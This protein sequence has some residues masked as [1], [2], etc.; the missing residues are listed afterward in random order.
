MTKKRGRFSFL[1]FFFRNDRKLF[2]NRILFYV[3]IDR[4]EGNKHER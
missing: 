3:V 4:E 1:F 2:F